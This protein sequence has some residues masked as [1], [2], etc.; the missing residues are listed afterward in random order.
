[1]LPLM[2]MFIVPSR[3]KPESVNFNSFGMFHE[4]VL[5]LI[6]DNFSVIVDMIKQ[7]NFV[8]NSLCIDL[9]LTVIASLAVI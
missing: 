6:C 2:K 4:C 8:E 9:I 3:L 7:S 1:M 5:T